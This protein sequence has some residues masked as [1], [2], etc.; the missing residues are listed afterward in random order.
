MKD[1]A[2]AVLIAA[3]EGLSLTPAEERFFK[4]ESPAGVTLFRRNIP[5]DRYPDVAQLN[6]ALQAT[7]PP[8][9]PRL[10]IAVDQEGGRVSRLPSPFP[11]LGPALKIADGKVDLD[12]ICVLLEYGR[13]VGVELSRIGINVNFAPVLD[14]LTEP[15]NHAIGDRTFGTES[16]QITPR[17]HAFLTGMQGAGVLGCLKHFPGQGDAKVDTHLGTAEIDVSLQTLWHREM[18]PFREMY[19]SCP[20]IMI[21]HSI[22]PA[23][24]EKEASRSSI[25]IEDWLRGRIGFQGVVVSDDLNMGA[26]PQDLIDWQEILIE[27]VAA[28]CD[29]LLVCRHLDRCYAALHALRRESA[30]S[31]SFRVMLERSAGRVT[32]MRGKLV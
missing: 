4:E 30:K 29:A 16:W 18:M 1:A 26:L 20:M 22:F 8:G 12:S 21:S 24:C 15:T 5:Q 10:V 19:L 28:G 27:C 7:R 14:I 31:P 3:V 17:A 23:L 2:S 11:N 32:S 6:D 9:D 25:I 13:A